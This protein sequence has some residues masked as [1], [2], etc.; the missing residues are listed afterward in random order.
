MPITFKAPSAQKSDL[1]EQLGKTIKFAP[2][3]EVNSSLELTE[4]AVAEDFAMKYC[5]TLRF[6]HNEGKWYHWDGARWKVNETHAAFDYAR[7]L[8]RHHR[9][10]DTRLASRKAAEGVEYMARRDQRLAVTSENWN[11][12]QFLLGTPGGTIDLKTG[13]LRPAD[14]KDFITQ[15]TA[16]APAPQGTPHPAFSKFLAEAT[17]GDQELEHFL[18]QFCGYCL[19]GS[20]EAQAF[21]FIYGPG[22]NGKSVFQNVLHELLADYSKPAPTETFVASKYQ[23]HPTNIAMLRSARLVVASETEKGQAWSDARINQLTG[24]DP[25]PARFMRQDYFTFCPRFKLLM[26]GNHK[27]QLKTV[28]DAARRR[29]MIVPFLNKPE[30]PDHGLLAKLQK[31]YPAILQWMIDGCRDWQQHG[32]VRPA[33]IKKA[34]ADYFDEQDLFG[35]WLNE[36]CTQGVGLK[37]SAS[38]LYSSWRQFAQANGEEAGT[39]KTFSATLSEHGFQSKKSSSTFYLGIEP[40]PQHGPQQEAKN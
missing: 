34:T 19:T 40:K 7:Q 38:E 17:A 5:N 22:G 24:G 28:N 31:E 33:A 9:K 15:L 32:L 14:P 21:L 20:T 27:P 12:D 26:V 16:V 30:Q 8:C 3:V 6:D 35:R 29:I 10:G 39:Y 1:I 36:C 4:D 2:Q 13:V 23:S 25:V 18:Q 11:K 37:A